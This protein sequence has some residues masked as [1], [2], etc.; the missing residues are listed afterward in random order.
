M[1][2]E[3]L[4]K[5][6]GISITQKWV[7][8][9]NTIKRQSA[10]RIESRASY[11]AY[12]LWQITLKYE[13]L[14]SESRPELE[15][16]A[17][18]FMRHGGSLEDFLY[19]DARDIR[20]LNDPFGQG[21]GFTKAFRL[22]RTWG[23]SRAPVSAVKSMGAIMID[24]VPLAAGYTYD[25]NTGWVTFAAAPAEGALLTWSGEYY[26]RVRFLNDDIEFEQILNKWWQAGKIELITVKTL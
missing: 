7:P 6:A 4:P 14:R 25:A 11:E 2:N 22:W 13:L 23:G 12:P 9:H 3:V 15:T 19:E 21:D 17:G 8:I 20:T 18:F 26:W 24:G 10:T 1:S 16:M 5:Y